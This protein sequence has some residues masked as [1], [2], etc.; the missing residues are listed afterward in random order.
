MS[1]SQATPQPTPVLVVYADGNIQLTPGLTVG[2]VLRIVESVRVRALAQ[3][4]GIPL[5]AQP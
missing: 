4:F 5:E 1:D 3:P 2:D